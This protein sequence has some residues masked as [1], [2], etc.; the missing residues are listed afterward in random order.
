M[1]GKTPLLNIGKYEVLEKI[2]EGGFGIVYRGRDP[3]L[4]REVAI[5]VLKSDAAT[6]PDFVER[7]RREAR[8]AASL[9]H[10]NIATVIEVGENEGRYYLVMG[11]LSG[12]P[13]S[14]L[15]Q[16]GKPLSLARAVDLL[17]PI[18][19]ALDHAH[20][21]GIIHRDVKPSNIL[22]DE[23]GQPV[24]T[25][26]G[27]VKSLVED[28][29]TSSG[30]TLGTK[31]YMAPEQIQGQKPGTAIDIYALGIVA[32]ELFVGQVPFDGTTTFEIQKKHVD[33][34]PPDPCTIN[35]ALPRTIA[36]DLLKALEKDPK[37]RYTSA[38]QFIQAIEE[39]VDE[40][41]YEQW[42]M[43]LASAHKQI[44]TLDF[45]GALTTLNA[46][47]SIRSTLK[48]DQLLEEAQRRKEILREVQELRQQNQQLHT[49][50]DEFA[51]AEA[52]LPSQQMQH[53]PSVTSVDGKR[54][55]LID[56]ITFGV[57][58]ILLALI[59]LIIISI[60]GNLPIIPGLVERVIVCSYP[61]SSIKIMQRVVALPGII[62]ISLFVFSFTVLFVRR[63]LLHMPKAK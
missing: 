42:E 14:E 18:A 12:G 3:M 60:G 4:E 26:F 1:S 15:L 2:G 27:L 43:L 40:F 30:V 17:K 51:A 31:K 39:H 37:N 45:D 41:I 56:H 11:Y 48:I 49:R 25:D 33:E 29:I 10:P 57:Y 32:Y 44:D 50:L 22:L 23:D 62:I 36:N 59:I 6:S 35:P 9:R 46:A 52:W 58:L 20:S 7:F 63:Y 16:R 34:P 38:G 5:K 28:S 21:K 47:K 55:K 19:D 53:K 54:E 13:L 24:L 8:M 61:S